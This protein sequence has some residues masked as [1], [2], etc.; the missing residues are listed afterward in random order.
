MNQCSQLLKNPVRSEWSPTNTI[1]LLKVVKQVTELHVVKHTPTVFIHTLHPSVSSTSLDH[2]N[3][4]RDFSVRNREAGAPF[5]VFSQRS[6]TQNIISTH[7]LLLFKSCK[8]PF[9]ASPFPPVCSIQRLKVTN[10][11]TGT[12]YSRLCSGFSE[13]GTQQI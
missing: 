3:H 5:A 6:V 9:T 4:T 1:E 13:H 10:T 7:T 12:W 8:T 2:N 11:Q